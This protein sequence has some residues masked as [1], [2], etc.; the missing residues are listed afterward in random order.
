[1]AKKKKKKKDKDMFCPYCGARAKLVTAKE[2]YGDKAQNPDDLIYICSNYGKSCDAYVT[3]YPGTD[4]P[5][6]FMADSELRRMRITAHKAIDR[7]IDSG[8]MSKKA[9]YKYL[10]QKLC[11]PD[12]HVGKSGI[13]NCQKTIKIMNDIANNLKKERVI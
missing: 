7:V 13:Y 9:I 5:Y 1:M 4:K 3:T 6:G 11:E 12:F 2:V 10:G 8:Y